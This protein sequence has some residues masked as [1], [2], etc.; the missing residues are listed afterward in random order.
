MILNGL[1]H[2]APQ[3]VLNDGIDNELIE[4]TIAQLRTQQKV[5]TKQ[6]LQNILEQRN[7]CSTEFAAINETQ[8]RLEESLWTCQKARSY[9]NFARTN[10]TTTSLEILASYRKREVLKEVLDTLVAIKTLVS[11]EFLLTS[12]L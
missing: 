2:N 11:H 10:L 6:V 7:A 3:K 8:K 4:V 12:L 9:L 1:F 5:L